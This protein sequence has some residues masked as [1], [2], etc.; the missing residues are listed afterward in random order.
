MKYS[1]SWLQDYIE[2]T[3]ETPAMLERL[4]MVGSDVEGSHTRG[5]SS[6]DVVVGH[7]LEARPHPNADRLQICRVADGKGERQIVCGAKNFKAGDKAPLALP[8]AVLPGDFVIK[9][10]KIRG[11]TSEGMLC[12]PKELALAEESEGILI[13]PLDAPVGARF[14]SLEIPDCIFELEITPNRPDLLSYKGLARELIAAGIA[15]DKTPPPASVPYPAK[16]KAPVSI[17]I[18]PDAAEVCAFFS[19]VRLTNVKVGPSP[20]WLAS[21][22]EAMGHRSINNVVDITNFVL[23]EMGQPLHAYD[24]DKLVDGRLVVRRARAGEKFLA[25]NDKEYTMTA[26]DVVIADGKRPVGLAGVIGGK[27]TGVSESTRNI[28]LETAWFTPTR[29]RQMSRRH[30]ILTDSS[31]RFERRVNPQDR[32]IA[33]DRAVAL[34]VE[35][36][37]G[38]IDGPPTDVGTLPPPPPPVSLRPSRAAHVMGVSLSPEEI[39]Q[40]LTS[41][42]LSPTKKEAAQTTWQIPTARADLEREIDLI[43]EV[44]RLYGLDRIEARIDHGPNPVSTA[45]VEDAKLSAIRRALAARGWQ[46]CV[47]DSLV[48]KAALGESA[49]QAIELQNPLNEQYTHLRPALQPS[50]IAI[51]GTNLARGADSLRLFEVNRVFVPTSQKDSTVAE[52]LH[53]GLLVA[54]QT[55]P[56]W[57]EPARAFDFYDLKGVVDWLIAKIGLL[58]EEILTAG[59][60]PTAALRNANIK[61]DVFYAEINLTPF[62]SRMAT[63]THF[64]PLTSYPAVRRDMALV[65]DRQTPQADVARVFKKLQRPEMES[66]ALFD[67]FEDPKGV[68]LPAN[69]KSLAYSV[70]YRSRERT[71]TE[72]EVNAWQEELKRALREKL[73]CTFRES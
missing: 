12:S 58:P 10:S 23:W 39:E 69:Q 18:Q 34:L 49:A 53:L 11:E 48:G 47:G 14:D 21:K 50:L 68:K 13:L 20:A 63:P 43:E 16:A 26:D 33:R 67:V 65:I 15:K 17:E 61:T 70:V 72:A 42:G 2:L 24:A 46:E 55:R 71:L 57:I 7:I 41:L 5:V 1:L 27:E 37:G 40:A 73:S 44:A 62:L 29:V 9:A 35:L 8:G 4:I 45:D 60:L 64:E 22:I 6:P 3:V 56:S 19:G 32:P 54:G 59:Q 30:G 36:T 31:H 28:I 66:V 51:A 52:P 38:Q 25:L